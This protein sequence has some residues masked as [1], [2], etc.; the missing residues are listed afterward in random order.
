MFFIKTGFNS[1]SWK[2]LIHHIQKN[3]KQ[4]IPEY[5]N[6]V[7]FILIQNKNMYGNGKF[8]YYKT[9]R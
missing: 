4:K 2:A 1:P 3:K 9:Y 7:N 8:Y 6:P 5:A